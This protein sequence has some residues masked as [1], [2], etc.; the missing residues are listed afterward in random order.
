VIDALQVWHLNNFSS[1]LQEGISGKYGM[2]TWHLP[3]ALHSRGQS[4]HIE[5]LKYVSVQGRLVFRYAH[6]TL[7]DEIKPEFIGC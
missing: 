1:R 6:M 5:D 7:W 3:I 2:N 4:S